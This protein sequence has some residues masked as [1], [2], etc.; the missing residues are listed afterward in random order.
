MPANGSVSATAHVC[1][2]RRLQTPINVAVRE[3]RARGLRGAAGGTSSSED[4]AASKA[5]STR[6]RTMA[7]TLDEH[8]HASSY[9]I[10]ATLQQ[11]NDHALPAVDGGTRAGDTMAVANCSGCPLLSDSLDDARRAPAVK[12]KN[13]VSPQVP[14]YKVRLYALDAGG[15]QWREV[16]AS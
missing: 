9:K 8:I 3:A 10:V 12:S 16:E 4:K 6:K 14:R 11:H 7:T 5:A 15:V 13:R 1:L 2:Q